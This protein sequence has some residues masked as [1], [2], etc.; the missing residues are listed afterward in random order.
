M[1]TKPCKSPRYWCG[2]VMQVSKLA[3]RPASH[4]AQC[5][6]SIETF[7]PFQR[8][9]E[10]TISTP[11]LLKDAYTMHSSLLA[12]HRTSFSVLANPAS[13]CPS[14]VQKGLK[15][16]HTLRSK[17]PL[18]QDACSLHFDRHRLDIVTGQSQLTVTVT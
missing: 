2:A 16:T 7:S 13:D 11:Y 6:H 1:Q 10:T 17:L 9:S 5:K 14:L 8:A 15:W 12:K 3:G 18:L 4:N